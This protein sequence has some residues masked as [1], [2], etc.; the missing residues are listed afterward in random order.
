V[1]GVV[2]VQIECRATIESVVPSFAAVDVAVVPARAEVV[3]AVSALAVVGVVVVQIECRVMIGSVVPSFV[4]V[5]VTVV[6]TVVPARGAV[7][8]ASGASQV[9]AVEPARAAVV[10]SVAA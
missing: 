7:H 5:V 10:R 3:E 1:G 8:V 9:V 4:A 6:V 2:V